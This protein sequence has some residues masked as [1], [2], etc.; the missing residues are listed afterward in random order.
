MSS[1]CST[2][3]DPIDATANYDQD[4]NDQGDYDSF[5][6]D[7]IP[8][9]PLP[10]V[11]GTG[12][13]GKSRPLRI[14]PRWP[15]RDIND[16]VCRVG[17]ERVAGQIEKLIGGEIEQI[18]PGLPGARYL[19]KYR[20]VDLKWTFHQVVVKNGRVYDAFTGYL[21]ASISEYKAFWENADVIDF[22]F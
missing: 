5:G 10:G 9:R 18:N 17:C 7:G 2:P 20:T 19:G 6:A 12:K 4:T 11:P 15:A 14:G 13:P 21:G 8:P 3:A 16:P 1:G 22:G